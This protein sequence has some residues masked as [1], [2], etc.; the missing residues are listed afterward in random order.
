MEGD[1]RKAWRLAGALE[2][3]ATVQTLEKSLALA[4]VLGE[5]SGHGW[6]LEKSLATVEA[7][8]QSLAM[9]VQ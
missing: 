2:S 7:L 8:E 4:G 9:A 3:L 5:K 1:W 6:G